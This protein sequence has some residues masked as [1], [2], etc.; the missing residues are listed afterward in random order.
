[1]LD[2]LLEW[3][4]INVISNTENIIIFTNVKR[5]MKENSNDYSHSIYI[6]LDN[7]KK[8][9]SLLNNYNRKCILEEYKEWLIDDVNQ[10]SILL[11]RDDPII[12]KVIIKLINY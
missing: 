5:K 12:W 8:R 6:A 11:L 7:A 1:M 4:L 3:I 9:I 10:H 2:T